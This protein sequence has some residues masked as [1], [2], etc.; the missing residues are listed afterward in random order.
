MLAVVLAAILALHAVRDRDGSVERSVQ[1]LSATEDGTGKMVTLA[2]DFGVGAAREYQPVAWREGI[3][4]AD[5]LTAVHR[6]GI[7]VHFEQRGSGQMAFLTAL[8]GRRNEGAGGRNWIYEVNG[9]RADRS[10]AVYELAP[11]DRVLWEF[12]AA[13]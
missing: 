10:F 12:A 3:T 9:K 7:R 2:I 1:P 5:L 8:D 4:V 6:D 11:G 13:E